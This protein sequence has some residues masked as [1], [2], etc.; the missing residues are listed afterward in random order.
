MP[1]LLKFGSDDDSDYDTALICLNGHVVNSHARSDAPRNRPFCAICGSRTVSECSGCHAPIQ[2]GTFDNHYGRLEFVPIRAA[3]KFCDRCGNAYVWTGKRIEAAKELAKELEG[4]S[5]EE[6]ST[7]SQSI[8]DLVK[9]G[10]QTQV[11]IVRS[12]KL[13]AKVTGPAV[14]AFRDVVVEIAAAGAAAKIFG[15]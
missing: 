8:D 10:P 6:R 13:L 15:P 2:G 1:V 12:R 14:R 9:D 3:P 4:L 7:L 11:A 5:E